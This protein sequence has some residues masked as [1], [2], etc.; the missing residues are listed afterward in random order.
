MF[1]KKNP[2]PTNGRRDVRR[3]PQANVF[4]YYASRNPSEVAPRSRLER[5]ETSKHKRLGGKLALTYAPSYLAGLVLLVCLVYVSTL[6]SQPNV[7]ITG[8]TDKKTLIV[9][10]DTYEYEVQQ[11]LSRSLLN[12]SKL[13]I[14]TDKLASEIESNF[15]ELG[16]VSVVLPLVG[17]RPIVEARPA[18]QAIVLGAEDG[19]FIIDTK[20]RVLAVTSEVDSYL[21]DDLPRVQ[22]QSGL[23]SERGKIALTS[24]AVAFIREVSYQLKEKRIP[25]QSFVLPATSANE[26]RVRVQGMPYFVRFD[27]RGE[28]RQQVGTY[29]AVKQRL[30]KD[31]AVPKQYID[32]R[33]PEKAFYK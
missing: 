7:H 8:A 18:R 5:G 21:W 6:S 27:V 1:R 23:S 29:I 4:S 32:V 25:V 12:Q 28:G 16:D 24:E 17:R 15:P 31:G 33:V 11:L 20:G 30:E 9:D 22:D 14:N 26:L 19:P 13:L 3:S 10:A 2:Q